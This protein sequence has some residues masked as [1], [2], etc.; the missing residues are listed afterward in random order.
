MGVVYRARDEQLD[1]HVAVKV[2]MTDFA[3][4]PD[5][6]ARF[7]REA[8]SAGRLLH[9]NI[10]TI[11]DL[12]DDRG[13]AYI[14]MELLAGATLSDYMARPQAA[15]IE[16]KVDLMMQVC[17]GLSAAHAAG[18]IHRDIKPGN[19]FVLNDGGLKIL[20]FGVARLV[21]SS[22]TVRGHIIGTP[23]YMSPEQ[24]TGRPIDHRSDVFSAGGVFYWML[25]SRKP[26]AAPDL[27]SVLR[28]VQLED[29][30]ALH[31]E[32]APAP[33][34]RIVFRALAK[35]PAM[36]YQRIS[37]MLGDLQRFQRQFEADALRLGALAQGHV[38]AIN[39]LHEGMV[40]LRQ[41][42]GTGAPEAPDPFA[43]LLARYPVLA[44]RGLGSLGTLTFRH[45]VT[46]NIARDLERIRSSEEADAAALTNQVRAA[47]AEAERR[48]A[49][50]DRLAREGERVL[51]QASA[52]I[53]AG[54]FDDAQAVLEEAR[55][56]HQSPG[57][58]DS[59]SSRLAERRASAAAE[60]VLAKQA[61][62]AVAA[63]HDLFAERRRPEA[64]EL[65]EDFLAEHPTATAVQQEMERMR[66]E[67]SA[68]A[69]Q[70]RRQA[71]IDALGA[72]AP[73][74][75]TG[76][77]LEEAATRHARVADLLE[78]ARLG[79]R[80]GALRQTIR[81]CRS[82]EAL[83]PGNQ[84]AVTLKADAEKRIGRLHLALTQAREARRLHR[85]AE[86]RL[87]VARI[88]M[89][90]GRFKRA[91]DAASEALAAAPGS[92]H[93]IAIR[94]AAAAVI[95]LDPTLS[96]AD[97][98]GDPHDLHRGTSSLANDETV[99][100]GTTISRRAPD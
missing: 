77:R 17:D 100:T 3:E 41:R 19:L 53:E 58:V 72:S 88:A 24:A 44:E 12:G 81:A 51:Q 99:G 30:P 33:L 42:L 34:A 8:Q 91:Y 84:D 97:T 56:I 69:D 9:R 52:A 95:G 65:L 89:S 4:E 73:A 20:D 39:S 59:L 49:E 27:P 26:F 23:S 45:A 55:R 80:D 93:A 38:Q 63:A 82:A 66:R 90:L 48:T 29:P 60:H 21:T 15:D 75:L 64:I 62:E 83:E 35:D 68:A 40:G 67:A 14:V 5:V 87:F 86:R 6:R 43:G 46:E 85:A 47:E 36:R 32:E 10:I 13:R 37:D 96:V 31:D 2:L 61:D 76:G 70:E 11:F 22:M 54:R 98:A 18:I 79:L 92:P 78:R 16:S 1:R 7:Y 57:A 71:G 74:A 94:D 25:S 28:K 50:A